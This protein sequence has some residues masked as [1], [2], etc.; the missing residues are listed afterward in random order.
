[1][2]SNLSIYLRAWWPMLLPAIGTFAAVTW[3]LWPIGLAIPIAAGAALGVF[4]FATFI[5]MAATM[6][7]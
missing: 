1:M 7:D 5:Y 3:W 4:L 2:L 6:A